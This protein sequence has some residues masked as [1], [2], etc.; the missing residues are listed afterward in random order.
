MRV[1]NQHIVKVKVLISV[2]SNMR[3][4]IT[5][6]RK[7]Q[8]HLHRNL[9]N[10]EASNW[11]KFK[12]LEPQLLGLY[13]ICVTSTSVL[14]AKVCFFCELWRNFSL[15]SKFTS[16]ISL[17]STS[18]ICNSV[19]Y[20]EQHLWSMLWTIWFNRLISHAPYEVTYVM[21]SMTLKD[22]DECHQTCVVYCFIL[23]LL[24]D[25]LI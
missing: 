13:W 17:A 15:L 5:K 9:R 10:F 2:K 6:L 8:A 12:K 23:V 22:S 14:S 1:P 24:S 18:P 11:Q 16:S 19:P 20:K 4:L 21:Q 3:L 25:G 7:M